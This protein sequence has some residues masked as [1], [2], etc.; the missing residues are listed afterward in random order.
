MKRVCVLCLSLVAGAVAAAPPA[1]KPGLWEMTLSM[2]M[3][4]MPQGMQPMPPTTTRHC[5][6][7]E[8]IKDLRRTVPKQTNCKMEHWKES[9]NTVSWR[10]SCSGT[11]MTTMTGSVTYSGD[12]YSG[13]GK[14]TMN[15]GGRTVHMTQKYQARRVGDCK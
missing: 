9:G 2:E 13:V 1:M 14:A 11:A 12:S 15:V 8:D 4:G 5:Y 7:A 6:R 3:S 10:M